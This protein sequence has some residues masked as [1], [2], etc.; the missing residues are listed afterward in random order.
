MQIIMTHEQADFD[1][2]ASVLGAYLLN[3]TSLPVLPRHMNRN[4]RQFTSDFRKSFPFVESENLPH[5]PI[6][7][8]TLVDTQ[9]LATLKGMSK[10][11]AVHV[12]DHHAL[13]T[14][15]PA[16]WTISTHRI[17]ACTTLFVENL[18]S[19]R[20]R[21]SISEATLLLLGI[22]EDT[23]S[24]TYSRTTS[25]DAHAAAFLLE[26]GASLQIAAEFLNPPLSMEQKELYDRLLV[27]LETYPM[28]G[29][30]I[31]ISCAYAP[32]MQDEVSSV[33]HKL[34]D[35]LDPAA[36]FI[37]V[38][39]MEGIRLVAR[40]TTDKVNVGLIAMHF[41]G[42]GHERAASALIH[43]NKDRVNGEEALKQAHDELLRILP[44]YI[45]PDITVGQ[46]M[47]HNPL[48]ISPQTSLQEAARL[49]KKYGYEGFPVIDNHQV[50]G[51]L[52]RRVVD[53]AISHKLSILTGSLM[54]AGHI[55]VHPQDTLEELQKI[56][57]TSNWGQIPV[58]DPQTDKVIGI[59]TRT[60]LIKNLNSSKSQLS[61][62]PNLSVRLESALSP[63]RL[64]LLRTVAEQAH[65]LHV[66]IYIVGGFVRDLILGKPSLDFDIVVEG[67]AIELGESLAHQLGGTVVCH[68]RFGTA[69]WRIDQIRHSLIHKL[70]NQTSL[71][72]DDLP[73]S[74]DLI[75]SR[76]EFYDFPTALPTVE[77][78][79]IKLDLHR[80]DFSINTMALRLDGQHY[81]ELYDYW[82]GLEDLKLG[83]IRV[84]H[85]LSFV[86]DPTR[87]LRAV[88]FEQRF[89]FK[90]ESRTLQLMEEAHPLL[91]KLSDD[92]LRHEL[93][94]ILLE[95]HPSFILNRLEELNLL[96]AVHPGLS[97]RMDPSYDTLLN[98]APPSE[99]G[100]PDFS[101][102]LGERKAM[103][104]L[105]WFNQMDCV[106]IKE[107]SSRLRFSG[108]LQKALDGF[109]S[110]REIL[111]SLLSSSPSKITRSFE[112]IP[113]IT[114]YAYCLSSIPFEIKTLIESYMTKWR[115]IHP[116]TKGKDLLARNIP[117]GP[118]YRKILERLQ[119][120]WI[121]EEISSREQEDL[122]LESLLSEFKNLS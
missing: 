84:L 56:M 37:F 116:F 109:C 81:G 106:Q 59:V 24:L 43:M 122:C 32:E 52:T 101:K 67:N 34:R 19:N 30:N 93:D 10:K 94:L 55:F 51:L 1:A 83:I 114:L 105:L 33:A 111:P 14:N 17:G 25:R 87:L 97:W 42:G 46:I 112:T 54:E 21:L 76:T 5:G 66:S 108:D 44:S 85:S 40:S 78:S 65:G 31:L 53:R 16:A 118:I 60:D 58:I 35:F 79:S 113:L 63:T 12:I 110:L 86:D 75:S 45:Q 50:V 99:W 18:R 27:N 80:R 4:V 92:R 100:L 28:N 47:S 22:Y 57:T 39:T 91:Q 82:G 103:A 104:Y 98:Q 29:K 72:P 121:D 3:P 38:R 73:A 95:A 88:R 115:F 119:D 8:V 61:I 36:L 102:T 89:S 23:G 70:K 48:I 68:K 69:K 49:M 20:I 96:R 6:Q 2:V 120:A 13:K 62:K 71:D 74:L 117:T 11:T 77:R 107:I 26:Q 7:T 41:H 9:S 15:T 64:A 90:I